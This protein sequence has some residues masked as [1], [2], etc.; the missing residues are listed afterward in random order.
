MAKSYHEF[1]ERE[2]RLVILRITAEGQ[3]VANDRLLRSGLEHWGL[4]CTREQ[5][6]QSLDWLAEQ[7]LVRQTELASSGGGPVRRVAIT[8]RGRDVA[9][10]RTEVS[11]VTPRRLVAD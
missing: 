8:A 9:E 4:S 2:R 1:A 11:G 10:G 3:G 7:G 5:V 6:H